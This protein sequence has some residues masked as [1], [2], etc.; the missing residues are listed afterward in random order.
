MP[1]ALLS[2]E[3]V[4]SLILFNFLLDIFNLS[5]SLESNLMVFFIGI[6]PR[7]V[8]SSQDIRFLPRAH[9]HIASD[10]PPPLGA[11]EEE[12]CVSSRT[13]ICVLHNE[14]INTLVSFLSG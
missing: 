2:S 10:E 1:V 7:V 6:S 5:C 14:N 9:R 4:L 3:G 13:T 12:V 8:D 11:E